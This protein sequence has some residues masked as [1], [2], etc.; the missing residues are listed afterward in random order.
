MAWYLQQITGDGGRVPNAPNLL[1]HKIFVSVFGQQQHFLYMREDYSLGD[2]W[3]DVRASAWNIQP[4]TDASKFL[5]DYTP[6]QSVG[7]PFFCVSVYLQ[8]QHFAFTGVDGT[9]IDVWY[10]GVTE[11]WNMQNINLGR[12]GDNLGGV[13]GG[14]Q[15][16]NPTC[17]S[18][19]CNPFVSV[20]GDQQHFA[21][22]SQAEWNSQNGIIWDAWYDGPI[23][24]WNLQQINFGG[25]TISPYAASAPFVSVFLDQ[26]HFAY[27]GLDGTIWDAWY[28]GSTGEWKLQQ[29]NKGLSFNSEGLTDGPP[30]GGQYGAATLGCTPFVSVFGTQQ[31][32]TY[33]D[34]SFVIWDAWYD[35]VTGN[36]NLQKVNAGGRTNGPLAASLPFVSVF[37]VQQHFTYVDSD[38]IIWDAWY[39]GATGGWNLQQINSG[40]QTEGPATWDFTAE[41][42]DFTGA[43]SLNSSLFVWVYGEEQH[44]SYVG[45]DGNMWD[46]Y[47][48]ER[49]HPLLGHRI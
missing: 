6:A 21:Y 2:I 9:I 7:N 44:F 17:P 29:I 33:V 46:A 43:P 15:S 11:T 25:H 40:G 48:S 20:F 18:A 4:I 24:R 16:G 45:R 49:G 1:V 38:L 34:S 22:W 28:D 32:F 35:G 13:T 5:V 39:D 14:P 42:N 26:Q 23:G 41:R 3:H 8:Q 27:G 31:H 36:W 37:G 47:Q 12:E 10:D 30:S 19:G